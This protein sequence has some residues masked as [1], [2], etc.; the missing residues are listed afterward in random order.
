MSMKYVYI[1]YYFYLVY[2]GKSYT[3]LTQ[4]DHNVVYIIIII[5]VYLYIEYRRKKLH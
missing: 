1:S 4:W 3:S 2:N 5:I